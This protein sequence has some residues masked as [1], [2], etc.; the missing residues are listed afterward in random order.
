MQ[1]ELEIWKPG[2]LYHLVDSEA[3]IYILFKHAFDKIFPFLTK[4]LK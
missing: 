1:S 4:A 3:L 2:M